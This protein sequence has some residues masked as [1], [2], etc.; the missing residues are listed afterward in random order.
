VGDR[1]PGR[2][3]DMKKD[4]YRIPRSLDHKYRGCGNGVVT[5]EKDKDKVLDF[6]YTDSNLNPIEDQNITMC[7][8]VG[9]KIREDD[10]TVTYRANFSSYQIFLY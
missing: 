1:K 7:D 8:D 9:R 3:I 2:S 5:L 4:A 10:K 6:S